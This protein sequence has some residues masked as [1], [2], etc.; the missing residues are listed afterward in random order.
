ME[1]GDEEMK[2]P[3][4]G[5]ILFL[6]NFTMDYLTL[7]VT[8]A[9][10]HRRGKPLHLAAASALGALYGV[11]ACFMGGSVLFRLAINLAVS[12]LMCRIAFGGRGLL[13]CCALFYGTGCLLGGAMT[14]LYGVF[15][16]LS[17]PRTVLI[18]GVRRTVFGDIPPVAMALIAVITAAAAV[19]GGQYERRKRSAR[20]VLLTIGTAV[21]KAELTALR[22]SG[23]LLT[24]PAS[25]RPVI[26]VTERALLPLL[27]E[28][29]RGFFRRGDLSALPSLPPDAVRRIRAIPSRSVAGSALLLGYLP[30][31]IAVD[32]IEK[33]AVLACC[34]ELTAFGGRD[35]LIPAVLCDA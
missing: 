15:D 22:D 13:P 8:S 33:T 30:E 18:D 10:L 26:L 14:A 1:G 32:G 28:E 5:D 24:D 17:G 21:G 11:A 29:L 23:N 2:Q 35:A 6:V 31:S 34:G 12:L 4:Y 20:E 7:F 3:L 16:G 9:A 25:G 27:P 19:A